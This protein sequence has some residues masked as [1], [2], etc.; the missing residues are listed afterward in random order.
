MANGIG[1]L[2]ASFL[3]SPFPTTIYIGHPGWKAMGARA[4]YSIVNGVVVTVLCLTGGI[5]LILRVVPLDE[6]FGLRTRIDPASIDQV[7]PGQPA[8]VRFPAFNQ[9]STPELAGSVRDVSATTSVDEVTGQ[10]FYW[11]DVA[12]SEMELARL[13]DLALV[14][15]MPVGAYLTTTDR[16]V[17]S[18][19]TKP[20]TDQLNQAFRED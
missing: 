4:G 1:T 6:G 13:G 2:V 3:A 16:T 8:K 5:N 10:S 7:Y 14:P 9:R 17:L 19:L 12:V 15:G 18:Y 11:V 20:L